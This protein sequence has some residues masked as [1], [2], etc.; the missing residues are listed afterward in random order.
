M[1]SG[2]A[3]LELV[4]YYYSATIVVLHYGYDRATVWIGIGIGKGNGKGIGIFCGD[5][6]CARDC[7]ENKRLVGIE[8][9]IAFVRCWN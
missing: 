5:I 2:K 8:K 1:P 9:A 7:I 6:L 3:L 4:V